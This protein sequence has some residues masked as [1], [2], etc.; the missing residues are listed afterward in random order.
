MYLLDNWQSESWRN[1]IVV[2][3]VRCKRVRAI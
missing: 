2:V 3:D 1:V